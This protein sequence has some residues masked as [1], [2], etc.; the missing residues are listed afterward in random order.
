VLVET[1][2]DVYVEELVS[3]VPQG[4]GP[5]TKELLSR[6]LKVTRNEKIPPREAKK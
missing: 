1:L 3:K 6:S 5:S 2:R 4:Q